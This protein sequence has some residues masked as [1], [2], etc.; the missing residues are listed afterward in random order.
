VVHVRQLGDTTY[1]FIVS[2]KLWRNSLIMMDEQTGSLWSHVTGE[3]LDG[4]LKGRRLEI[5]PA[6]QTTWRKWALEHPEAK[7]LKKEEEV[8]S[9]QYQSYFDDP[10]RAGMFRGNWLHDR[11]PGKEL[12]HGI[13]VGPHALAVSDFAL[14]PQDTLKAELGGKPLI[15]LRAPDGGVRA[16]VDEGGEELLVR[17]AFWFAW[18][19][20]YPNTLVAD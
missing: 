20:F 12:V 16:Y 9:S 8:R 2:G 19:S 6:I 1:T 18:S 13:V 7:L 15:V 3:A 17:P 11:L 4:A 10:D 14:G 5:L